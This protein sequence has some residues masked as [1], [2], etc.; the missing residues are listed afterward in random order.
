MDISYPSQSLTNELAGNSDWTLEAK[1]FYYAHGPL[2]RTELGNELQGLDYIYNLQGWLK[3]VNAT[4]LDNALD[5]GGDGTGSFS[6]DVMAFSL[7][8]YDGDYTPIGGVALQPAC[9]IAYS[10]AA[11]THLY[12]DPLNPNDDEVNLYNGNIR[13]MQT[14]LTKIDDGTPLPMLNAYKYDQLNRLLEARSY[15]SGLSGN[16]WSPTGYNN[17]YLNKFKPLLLRTL[18][19]MGFL[20]RKFRTKCFIRSKSRI[21]ISYK[22]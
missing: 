13:F 10:S 12:D 8:Y 14:T 4:S 6:K 9:S 2:A 15:E 17:E 3:G 11:A 21:F 16:T 20:I 1:Y 22:A 5:P 7:H 18:Y 19:R